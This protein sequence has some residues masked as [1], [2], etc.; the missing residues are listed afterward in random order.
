MTGP[1]SSGLEDHL[2][3]P[4]VDLAGRRIGRAAH[5]AY[6]DGARALADAGVGALPG[7]SLFEEEDR[8]RGGRA[9]LRPRSRE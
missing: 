7:P 5:S 4:P 3:G 8:R 6:V 2:S 1:D 9:V